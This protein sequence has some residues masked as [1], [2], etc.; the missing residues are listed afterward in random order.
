MHTSA[1]LGSISCRLWSNNIHTYRYQCFNSD[2]TLA[3]VV[4]PCLSRGSLHSA[5]VRLC[6][7]PECPL[8]VGCKIWLYFSLML[9][10]R[11]FDL[12]SLIWPED[13]AASALLPS[14]ND[15]M[16]CWDSKHQCACDASVLGTSKAHPCDH[17][18]LEWLS[19]YKIAIA[20]QCLDQTP[21]KRVMEYIQYIQY[22]YIKEAHNYSWS[23]LIHKAFWFGKGLPAPTIPK[24]STSFCSV[25]NFN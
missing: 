13:A 23:K 5:H 16:T 17:S 24:W 19:G 18:W 21:F 3:I 11:Q 7:P 14:F 4:G 12:R 25:L 1:C 9:S 6:L 20:H 2:F 8:S 15:V 22:I 10:W